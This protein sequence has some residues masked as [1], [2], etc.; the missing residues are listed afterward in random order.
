MKRL[1]AFAL[2]CLLGA[3]ASPPTS[4]PAVVESRTSVPAPA[5]PSSADE[6]MAYLARLRAMNE[7]A[8]AVEVSKARRDTTDM[9]RVKAAVA[10]SLAAQSDEGEI[11]ALV[12]PVERREGADRDVKAMAGFLHVMALERRRSKESAAARLRDERRLAE[13]QKQR[14]DGLQQKLDALTELEKS[15]SDRPTPSDAQAR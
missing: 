6:L 15:L 8:L 9:G 1:A 10:V 14:A 2:A 11:L 3:C 5:A 7:A 4:T 13:A 12:E